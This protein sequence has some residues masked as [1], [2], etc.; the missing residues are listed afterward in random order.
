M[1]QQK[2]KSEALSRA[3]SESSDEYAIFQ[4]DI[5]TVSSLKRAGLEIALDGLINRYK[6][7]SRA[8]ELQAIEDLKDQ[9]LSRLEIESTTRLARFLLRFL[10]S[11][12][13]E[14]IEAEATEDLASDFG[15]IAEIKS[16]KSQER[17]SFFVERVIELAPEFRRLATIDE[18]RTGILPRLTSYA[19]TVDLRPLFSKVFHA[20][21][22]DGGDSPLDSEYLEP[23]EWCAIHSIK[24]SLNNDSDEIFGFQTST[25]GLEKLVK[26]LQFSLEQAKSLEPTI[27][28]LNQLLSTKE[29]DKL[30]TNE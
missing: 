21:D 16:G 5:Q 11:L 30:S 15:V 17:I 10:R 29:P 8:E 14:E 7:P 3:F 22:R 6:A 9:N 13:D 18:F 19:T 4:K 12:D 20:D 27:E 26:R 23:T 24:L 25:F 2:L 28:K 1:D